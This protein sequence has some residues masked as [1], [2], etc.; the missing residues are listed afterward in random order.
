MFC[1][2]WSAA[3]TLAQPMLESLCRFGRVV[4]T[5][6]A[7]TTFGLGGLLMRLICFPILSLVVREQTRRE[8]TARLLIHYSFQCFIGL[9]RLLGLITYEIH[10][11]QRLARDGLLILANHPTLI[12]V[13]FLISLVRNAN[14]VV[15]SA[16]A[17]NPFTH[18]P[19]RA[20]GYIFN[21]QGAGLVEDCIRSLSQGNSLIVFPEGTRTCPGE[22]LKM[23][24][25]AA[26]IALRGASNITPVTIRCVPLGLSKGMAWWKVADR[27]L[28][29]TITIGP[30]IAVQNFVDEAGGETAVA[31]RNLTQYLVDYFSTKADNGLSPHPDLISKNKG[32]A[33]Q[34]P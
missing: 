30:D 23:Q 15:K 16:L 2:P 7:F 11:R 31:A 24:R 14:C 27:A 17:R 26:N 9:M 33:R 4:A 28:H 29:F 6:L 18:G 8:R 19:V 10:G 34:N 21:D 22:A 3:P 20:T 32:V 25:G 1:V 13:V 5:A 12:D